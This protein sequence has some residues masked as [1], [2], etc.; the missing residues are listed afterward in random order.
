MSGLHFQLGDKYPLVHFFI[1][2]Q[3]SWN[4]VNYGSSSILI[5]IRKM[6]AGF[7]ALFGQRYRVKILFLLNNFRRVHYENTPIQIY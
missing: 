1:R 4:L 5:I 6:L 3:M 2:R 7:K